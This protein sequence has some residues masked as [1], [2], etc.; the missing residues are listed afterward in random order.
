MNNETLHQA[1]E[2]GKL[3]QL[4]APVAADDKVLTK[5]LARLRS[6]LMEQL[7]CTVDT[8]ELPPLRARAAGYINELHAS[9]LQVIPEWLDVAVLLTCHAAGSVHKAGLVRLSGIRRPAFGPLAPVLALKAPSPFKVT[10]TSQTQRH[11]VGHRLSSLVRNA[12]WMPLL[13]KFGLPAAVIAKANG[14]LVQ[15]Y[16]SHPGQEMVPANLTALG[17]VPVAPAPASAKPARKK[18][19]GVPDADPGSLRDYYVETAGLTQ[20]KLLQHPQVQALMAKLPAGGMDE[21]VLE[22]LMEAT[23][24]VTLIPTQAAEEAMRS[25]LDAFLAGL[26]LHL[27]ALAR[28]AVSAKKRSD[29]LQKTKA[30]EALRG[31]GSLLDVL[32]SNPGLLTQA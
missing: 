15:K 19:A 25:K 2:A 22:L 26:Q 5:D 12:S 1:I 16:G 29:E 30:L 18:V 3:L 21:N 6:S 8:A 7:G 9:L 4:L 17:M 32:K 31:M 27:K 28:Q 13:L 14:M 10:G 24:V 11:A 20:D 23:Q